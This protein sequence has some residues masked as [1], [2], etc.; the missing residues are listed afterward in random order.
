MQLLFKIIKCAAWITLATYCLVK[1][2]HCYESYALKRITTSRYVVMET[3]FEYPA[4]T[5]CLNMDREITGQVGNMTWWPQEK[6]QKYLSFPF[7][8]LKTI[9][10][11]FC[12]SKRGWPI[13]DLD[14]NLNS[15]ETLKKYGMNYSDI[16]HAEIR[17]MM[18]ELTPCYTFTSRQKY[19]IG[20]NNKMSFRLKTRNDESILV[21]LA[22]HDHGSWLSNIGNLFGNYH[23]LQ[24]VN[25][26]ANMTSNTYEVYRQRIT[27]V[28]R[29]EYPC[30]ERNEVPVGMVKSIVRNRLMTIE[31]C[32]I[33]YL[34][35]TLNCSLLGL[36]ADT[37]V[38]SKQKYPLCI[39]DQQ[40]KHYQVL[41]WRLENFDSAKIMNEMKCV[42]S[43]TY[44]KYV[45][46]EIFDANFDPLVYRYG[47]D[48]DDGANFDQSFL[49][50]LP[51]VEIIEKFYMVDGDAVFANIGGFLGLLLGT[52]CLHLVDIVLKYSAKVTSEKKK[53]S[54]KKKISNE[55]LRAFDHIS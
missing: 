8:I 45:A 31:E 21:A 10:N 29:I 20:F 18:S 19:D 26:N 27:E 17:G 48:A 28:N 47:P 4:F 9:N 39:T 50:T 12:W 53:S 14:C 41:L 55:K 52:S 46:R 6:Y 49:F 22:V 42:P 40:F 34:Q 3:P 43:C 35:R 16:W 5:V 1:I 32:Y 33:D 24:F 13:K 44:N 25:S 54:I 51:D 7:E 15:L 2:Y 36:K 11:G 23:V 30:Y 37:D 38:N